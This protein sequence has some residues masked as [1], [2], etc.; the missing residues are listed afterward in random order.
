MHARCRSGNGHHTK[1]YKGKG[2]SVCD[3]WN[4]FEAFLED[5]GERPE[6]C[7]LSRIDHDLGY[8]VGNVTWETVEQNASEVARRNWESGAWAA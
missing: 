7:V 4:D 8:Q 5:M 3:R 1:H 6:G 2:I